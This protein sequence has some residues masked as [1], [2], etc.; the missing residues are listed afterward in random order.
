VQFFQNFAQQLAVLKELARKELAQE[1][2]S[3]T[4]LQ[5]LQ[6][7]VEMIHLSSGGPTY[8]G[9]YFSLF[10][11]RDYWEWDAIVADVHTDFPAAEVGDPG[12]VL[13]EAIGNVN[14]LILAVE[15]GGDRMMYAG[16]VLSH[17]EF[18]LPGLTRLADSEWKAELQAGKLPLRPAWQQGYLV[19]K[20]REPS[21]GLQ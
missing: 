7:I 13:H 10:Y 8:T 15:N 4:E 9:W 17:Y 20:E 16:P 5:F 19:P 2:F 21:E 11:K 1:P 3:E 18:R 12:C 6:T 14:M